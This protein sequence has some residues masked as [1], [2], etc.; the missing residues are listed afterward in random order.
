MTKRLGKIIDF[1][2]P[3]VA[4]I[5]NSLSPVN[6]SDNETLSILIEVDNLSESEKSE[7][8]TFDSVLTDSTTAN[9]KFDIGLY[10]TGNIP[11]EKEFLLE[12]LLT[13][14]YPQRITNFPQLPKEG[15][16]GALISNG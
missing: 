15:V 16:I 11:I 3:K 4:R 5:E 7:Q 13:V 6:E 9:S 12:I 1:F 10:V 14:G 8:V 2:L